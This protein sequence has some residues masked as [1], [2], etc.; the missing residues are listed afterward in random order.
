MTN[1]LFGSLEIRST[2]DWSVLSIERLDAAS[3]HQIN[4]FYQLKKS[5]QNIKLYT[6]FTRCGYY[7]CNGGI[8]GYNALFPV[9]IDS[10]GDSRYSALCAKLLF[11]FYENSTSCCLSVVD[12]Q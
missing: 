1:R 6:K 7:L 11:E 8:I 9:Q 2:N 12:L 4:P 5:F 3:N 10:E